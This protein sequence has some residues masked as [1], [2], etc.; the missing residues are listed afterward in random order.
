MF[1]L[2]DELKWSYKMPKFVLEKGLLMG[3]M[4]HIKHHNID[5]KYDKPNYVLLHKRTSKLKF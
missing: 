2:E 3:S 1:G 5:H 4:C